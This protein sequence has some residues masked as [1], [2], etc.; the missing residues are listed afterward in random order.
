MSALTRTQLI[1][2]DAVAWLVGAGRPVARLATWDVAE[3]GWPAKPGRDPV[4][5]APVP[6]YLRAVPMGGEAWAAAL[7]RQHDPDEVQPWVFVG[8]PSDDAV[9]LVHAATV[10]A[11]R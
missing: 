8:A 5:V 1:A 9:W 3:Q 7:R 4:M 10:A 2:L 11:H 6:E